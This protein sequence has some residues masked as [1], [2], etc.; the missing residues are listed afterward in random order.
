MQEKARIGITD[1]GFSGM[2][3]MNDISLY[4]RQSDV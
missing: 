2:V 3:T 1:A 4:C